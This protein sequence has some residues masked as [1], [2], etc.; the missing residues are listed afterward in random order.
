MVE[1]KGKVEDVFGGL[2]EVVPRGPSV[3]TSSK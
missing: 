1:G 3:V 2:G